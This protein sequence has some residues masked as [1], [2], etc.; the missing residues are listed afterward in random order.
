MNL[1]EK[2]SYFCNLLARLIVW[3]YEQGWQVTLGDGLRSDGHG[4][5]PSSLHYIGLAQ[6]LNLFVNGEWKDR[7]CPEW[8]AIGQHWKALDPLLCAWG[9]DFKSVDLNHFSLR[10]EGRA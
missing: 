2:Q 7:S 1:R 5:M 10:H 9:G 6:D 3:I 8:E 4:H